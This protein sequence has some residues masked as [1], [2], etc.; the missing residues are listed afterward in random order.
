[1]IF[2][3]NIVTFSLAQFVREW[4]PLLVV[5]T[6]LTLILVVLGTKLPVNYKKQ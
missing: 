5:L 2:A 3:L 1:M 6:G 4:W